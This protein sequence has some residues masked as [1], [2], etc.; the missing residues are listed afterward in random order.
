MDCIFC[1]IVDGK[2]PAPR[3]F[4][5]ENTI[6]IRDLS[7]QA[8]HHFL[9]IPKKHV[10]SL[11][12]LFENVSEGRTV[13][14]NLFAAA[15]ALANKEGLLPAGYRSVINTGVDGGQTVFHLH[16]HILGGEKMKGTFA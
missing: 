6:V 2:I 7:P 12:P 9:V 10:D 14:G 13:V 3:V 16:L 8:K 5:D 1:K 11:A 4:E 15:N